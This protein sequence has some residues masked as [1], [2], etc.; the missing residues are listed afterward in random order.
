MIYNKLIG[1]FLIFVS[2]KDSI[3]KPGT[4]SSSNM[5]SPD[6]QKFCSNQT[7]YNR[8]C[9]SKSNNTYEIIGIDYSKCSLQNLNIHTNLSREIR[10]K[11]EIL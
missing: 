11:I 2:L 6:V 4:C 5:T 7:I 10:E 9:L 1:W 8:C 3:C